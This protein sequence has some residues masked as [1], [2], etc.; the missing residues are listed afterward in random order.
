MDQPAKERPLLPDAIVAGEEVRRPGLSRIDRCCPAQNSVALESVPI[1]S[2]RETAAAAGAARQAWPDWARSDAATRARLLMNWADRIAA[3]AGLAMEIAR[4][5]GKPIRNSREEVAGTVKQLRALASRVPSELDL[6]QGEA[7]KVRQRAMGVIA[8]I[9]PWNNPIYIPAGK[10]G[11]ALLYG[12]SVVWKPA[13]AASWA[14]LRLLGL[15]CAAGAP[16]GVVNL[17]LGDGSTGRFLMEESAV[18]AVTLTGS[19]AA[20][21]S[22][23]DVCGR[24][25]IPLQAELGGNNAA[26]VWSDSDL[27]L[28]ASWIAEGAFAMAGQRCTA[29]RRVIVEERCWEAF[30]AQL[31]PEVARLRVGDPLDPTTQVGPVI[32][33]EQRDTL[34]SVLD[35]ASARGVSLLAPS[36]IGDDRKKL[37]KTGAYLWPTIALADDPGDE[38]V[39]EETFGPILVVQ[40]AADWD[41]AMARCN[42]VRQGLAAALFSDSPDLRHRFFTEAQAGI[43]KIN[44]S[45]A[46][47]EVDFPFGGW[48]ASG[49]GP[50][51]H[52]ASDQEFHTRTQTL[53]L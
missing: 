42:G 7:I 46:G 22:A 33:L 19:A 26:I 13:P 53:Y 27:A 52:G 38:L 49:F 2:G 48:K 39:Q 18:D 40:R 30:L 37:T 51:E 41:E 17:V 35:R 28:A 29:N 45:T 12:N 24:R 11:A 43:L 34:L 31:V 15:L 47:A 4:E 10:I 6:L 44:R 25:H 3:D 21:Y 50:P 20:G 23:Q 16:K 32:S 8:V 14:A 36:E 9:T 1:A 5:T